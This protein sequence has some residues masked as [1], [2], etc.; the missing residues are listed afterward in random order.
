M[1]AVTAVARDFVS[2]GTFVTRDRQLV[3]TVADM[4][5]CCGYED[6]KKELAG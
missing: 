3:A 1:A 4:G 5:D 2:A 6:M